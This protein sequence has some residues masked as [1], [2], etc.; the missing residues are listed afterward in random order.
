M[1]CPL[2]QVNPLCASKHWQ[3]LGWNMQGRGSK[4]IFG[5][6]KIYFKADQQ[7]T[8]L[9]SKKNLLKASKASCKRSGGRK[10]SEMGSKKIYLGS[11]NNLFLGGSKRTYL[12]S[13]SNLLKASKASCKR[14]GGRKRSELQQFWPFA[15]SKYRKNTAFLQELLKIAAFLSSQRGCRYCIQQQ[16]CAFRSWKYCT[17]QHF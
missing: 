5:I 9:G 7:K 1:I 12:G 11:S 13:K 8:Y 10:R 4:K 14:S 15:S 16:F 17:L 2:S 6:K 3:D